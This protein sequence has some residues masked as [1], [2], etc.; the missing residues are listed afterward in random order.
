MMV[1]HLNS[2][3]HIDTIDGATFD[4]IEGSFAVRWCHYRH[5]FG[6]FLGILIV[7]LSTPLLES[8]MCVGSK[9]GF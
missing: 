5:L 7:P 1:D 2:S 4:T 9:E 3:A 6:R 8:A